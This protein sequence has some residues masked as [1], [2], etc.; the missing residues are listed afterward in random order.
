MK[1]E[2]YVCPRTG[3]SLFQQLWMFKRKEVRE[4]KKGRA[5]FIPQDL[6][7]AVERLPYVLFSLVLKHQIKSKLNTTYAVIFL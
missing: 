3:A 7:R 1:L 4:N 6:T 5:V 2:D